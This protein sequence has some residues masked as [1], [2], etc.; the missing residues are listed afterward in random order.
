MY[1]VTKNE[2]CTILLKMNYVPCY[3]NELCILLLK[4]NYVPCYLK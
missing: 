4:I 2:L 3:Q 1:I